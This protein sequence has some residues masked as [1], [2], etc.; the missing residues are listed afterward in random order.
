MRKV[1]IY[2]GILTFFGCSYD[3]ANNI[4]SEPYPSLMTEFDNHTSE[5]IISLAY[6]AA[7]GETWRR[8]KTLFMDGYAIFYGN[9][10]NFKNEHHRM[11]RVYDSNK[12]D[13][14]TVDGK[15]RIESIREGK[16]L[17]NVSYDGQNTYTDGGQQGKSATDQRW[18]S[19]FGFGVIRHALDD[20]Y[21][22]DRMPDDLVDG[23]LSYV[24][25]VVDSSGGST[26]F[27]IT[28]DNYAIVK[29]AF[30]T[31]RGWHE[32]VYSDFFSNPGTDWSQPA[33]VRL[34]YNGVKSNEVIWEKFAV[35]DDLPNCVFI[36][37]EAQNCR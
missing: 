20:G 14:H 33:R 31:P 15:V 6:A 13:A 23:R 17:I 26:F 7:G 36:L 29:V 3:S 10:Q 34:Y 35:N 8:P 24:V 4:S 28:Q 11:W 37:P 1:F 21:S 19:S 30:D 16:P 32:R 25:K 27:H 18:S 2:L 22:V 12:T 5:N 9:G